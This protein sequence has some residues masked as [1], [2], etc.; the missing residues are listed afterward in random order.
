MTIMSAPS[1]LALLM[2]LFFMVLLMLMSMLLMLLLS[3]VLLMLTLLMLMSF[4]L[5][6]YYVCCSVAGSLCGRATSTLH[7]SCAVRLLL[8]SN[9]TIDLYLAI[10]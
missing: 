1:G 8:F 10:W 9:A 2:L 4:F 5:A 7:S 6:D 3:L